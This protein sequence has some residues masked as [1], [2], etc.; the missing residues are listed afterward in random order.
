MPFEK[1]TKTN[2]HFCQK[3]YNFGRS[4]AV[5]RHYGTPPLWKVALR[6][7]C[8]N[9]IFFSLPKLQLFLCFTLSLFYQYF[10]KPRNT[11]YLYII[12]GECS[13]TYFNYPNQNLLCSSP[14]ECPE[15][16]LFNSIYYLPSSTFYSYV[17][18]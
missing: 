7:R 6:L 4:A 13:P 2:K 9:I 18:R 3:I 1:K 14:F 16:T 11:T 8:G 12:R 10:I 15:A 17:N 5:P